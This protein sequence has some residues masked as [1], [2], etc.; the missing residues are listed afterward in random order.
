MEC[1]VVERHIGHKLIILNH[2]YA[3]KVISGNFLCKGKQRTFNSTIRAV[4]YSAGFFFF[5]FHYTL[6][7][8]LDPTME[9]ILSYRVEHFNGKG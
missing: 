8:H 9:N 1:T 7:S 2:T 3:L 6:I 5:F 4:W